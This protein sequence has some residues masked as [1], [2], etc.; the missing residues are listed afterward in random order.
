[1]TQRGVPLAEDQAFAFRICRLAS[2]IFARQIGVGGVQPSCFPMVRSSPV[3]PVLSWLNTV[4]IVFGIIT[5]QAIRGGAFTSVKA[6][7]TAIET[8]IDAWNKRCQPFISTKT[9][10]E[11]HESNQRSKIIVHATLASPPLS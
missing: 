4:Q 8:Y 9:T 1:M 10:N 6:L 2:S 7:T 5:G 11:I 3:G